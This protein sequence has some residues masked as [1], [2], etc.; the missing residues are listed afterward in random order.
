MAAGCIHR[1]HKLECVER[2]TAGIHLL[3]DQTDGL[4]GGVGAQ[5]DYGQLVG[6]EVL[7]DLILERLE[8][9]ACLRVVFQPVFVEAI[10]P[11]VPVKNLVQREHEVL[12]F[13]FR[14][15]EVEVDLPVEVR[16][17]PTIL[18]YRDNRILP[19][20][21]RIHC[22]SNVDVKP[23][24]H[25][26]EARRDRLHHLAAQAGLIKRGHALLAIQQ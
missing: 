5:C 8:E 20:L 22:F 25:E 13:E 23:A 26:L 2:L 14:R 16:L 1:C 11:F 9:L 7:K 18:G 17:D 15:G 3:K 4:V 10:L 24:L 21:G 6:L 19:V 12:V